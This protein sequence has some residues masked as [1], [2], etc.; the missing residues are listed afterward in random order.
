VLKVICVDDEKPVLQQIVS[1]CGEVAGISD[2]QAFSGAKEALAWVKGHPCDLALLDVNMPGMDGILLA[3][4]IKEIQPETEVVFITGHARYAV[5]AWA[6]HARGYLLKPVTAEQLKKETDYIMSIRKHPAAEHPGTHIEIKTFG[7][8][9]ILVDGEPVHFKRSKAKE[10]LACL[11]EKQGDSITREQAYCMI[12]ENTHYD[13][14][15]QKQLDVVIRSLR[16]TLEEYGI[17][18]ILSMQRG[19]LRI[20]PRMFSCDMYRMLLGDAEAIGEYRGEYMNAY[21]W[22]SLEEAYLERR[23]ENIS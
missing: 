9:D 23:I 12:W 7:G 13:R 19:M 20:E 22:A 8:F 5:D 2:I 3:R 14:S 6:V 15:A 11:V 4:E 1:L 16:T 21:S 18:E 10:L 17:S